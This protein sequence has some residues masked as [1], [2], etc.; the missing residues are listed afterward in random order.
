M[1][2]TEHTSVQPTGN[3]EAIVVLLVDAS[4]ESGIAVPKERTITQ[5]QSENILTITEEAVPIPE[6]E[7]ITEGL[8]RKPTIMD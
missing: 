1:T 6:T 7:G 5:L 8:T 2:E 3:M 4:K